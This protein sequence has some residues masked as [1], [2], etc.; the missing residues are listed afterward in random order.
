[1]TKKSLSDEEEAKQMFQKMTLTLSENYI[2]GTF[3]WL[4]END[5]ELMDK[6]DL[7]LDAIDQEW[8]DLRKRKTNIVRFREKLKEYY[9]N[10]MSAIKIFREAQKDEQV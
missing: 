5:P 4:G 1:M 3:E 7:G 6:I 8:L 9:K 2:D 10:V